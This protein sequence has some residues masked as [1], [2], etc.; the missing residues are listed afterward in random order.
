MLRNT[1]MELFMVLRVSVNSGAGRNPDSSFLW[2]TTRVTSFVPV[3][4]FYS[5]I[6][7]KPTDFLQQT[8]ARFENY[9]GESRQWVEELEQ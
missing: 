7:R 3:S 4:D 1:K 5:G 8:V 6:P 9:L 2:S